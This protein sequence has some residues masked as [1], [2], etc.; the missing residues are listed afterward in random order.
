ML[1]YNFHLAPTSK[2]QYLNNFTKYEQV[3]DFNGSTLDM[4][5]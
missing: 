3:L 1:E 2:N 5:V 4:C